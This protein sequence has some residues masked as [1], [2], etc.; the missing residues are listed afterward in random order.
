MGISKRDLNDI[1]GQLA[2]NPGD[3]AWVVDPDQREHTHQGES[4]STHSDGYHVR[5]D[6]SGPSWSKYHSDDK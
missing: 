3:E 1:A 6:G 4:G 2:P 5:N